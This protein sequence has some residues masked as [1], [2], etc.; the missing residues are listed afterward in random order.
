M[1]S[2]SVLED[3][4][5]FYLSGKVGQIEYGTSANEYVASRVG[6]PL[7]ASTR[8]C[9]LL[10]RPDDGLPPTGG[11]GCDRYDVFRDESGSLHLSINDS[12]PKKLC[13]TNPP[14]TVE[15]SG[16]PLEI[17]DIRGRASGQKLKNIKKAIED[18][19]LLLEVQI[20]RVSSF[21]LDNPANERA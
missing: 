9:S 8:V 11:G 3:A 20:P 12:P 5:P 16:W 7:K 17:L 6:S 15:D 10:L 1:G 21:E 18:R 14:G 4:Q 2:G 13:L 19:L